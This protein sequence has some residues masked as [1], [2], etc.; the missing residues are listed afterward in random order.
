MRL[1]NSVIP[2]YKSDK[3]KEKDKNKVI[4]LDDGNNED[5]LMKFITNANKTSRNGRK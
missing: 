1:Y 5:E 3:D 4:N 2:E